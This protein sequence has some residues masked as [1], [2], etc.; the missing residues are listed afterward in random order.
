MSAQEEIATIIQGQSDLMAQTYVTV[1]ALRYDTLLTFSS[2]ARFIW[3]KKFQ[4]GTILYL[5]ARY[6]TLLESLLDVYLDFASI[7]SVQTDSLLFARTYAISSH[8]K[9]VFIV[10]ALLGTTKTVLS[11][12]AVPTSNCI[13]SPLLALYVTTYL[14]VDIH[15]SNVGVRCSTLFLA[16]VF[17]ICVSV[18]TL[19]DILTIVVDTVVFVAIIENTLGP[20]KLQSKIPGFQR[21]SLLKLLVQQKK[22][23]EILGVLRYGFILTITLADT[24]TQKALRLS[25]QGILTPLNNFLSVILICRFHLD[26]QQRNHHPNGSTT[27]HS[28]PLRSFHA[29]TGRIHKAVVDEFG[30]LSFNESFGMEGSQHGIEMEAIQSPGGVAQTDL[31]EFTWAGEDIGVEMAGPMASGSGILVE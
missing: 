31:Q 23:R 8:K 27:S 19:I 30:D 11:I 17:M 12:V 10:L 15:S 3:Q 20:L 7:P 13:T 16:A 21:N 24:V 28:H 6:P 18:N 1:A 4:L 26:L 5:L 2:E 14:S 29:V 25:L 22:L 9:L